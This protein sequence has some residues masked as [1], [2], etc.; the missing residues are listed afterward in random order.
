MRRKVGSLSSVSTPPAAATKTS[1]AISA[2][3]YSRLALK[4]ISASPWLTDSNIDFKKASLSRSK[5]NCPP[6]RLRVLDGSL[7]HNNGWIVV[8]K[9]GGSSWNGVS[10]ALARQLQ[11]GYHCKVEVC[12]LQFLGQSKLMKTYR[13]TCSLPKHWTTLLSIM[14]TGHLT[15]CYH[16]HGDPISL[17]INGCWRSA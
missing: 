2:G 13:Q 8:Y 14:K 11:A 1:S 12:A 5:R 16:L 7:G 17:N 10:E 15:I 4:G 9:G 6:P 3:S